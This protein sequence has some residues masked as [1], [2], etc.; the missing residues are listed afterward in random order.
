[1]TLRIGVLCE[2]DS[3]R[4]EV[5]IATLQGVWCPWCSPACWCQ[6]PDLRLCLHGP[7]TSASHQCC[8]LT[9]T[10]R[11]V[12]VVDTT[13]DCPVRPPLHWH[14]DLVTMTATLTPAGRRP[15]AAP[16]EAGAAPPQSAGGAGV[17]RRNVPVLL[18]AGEE[19]FWWGS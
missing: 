3:P 5:F 6:L 18:V 13:A 9:S 10:P 4:D 14:W 2:S 7:D 1:M 17:V 11:R 16:G 15:P 8:L 12:D 19:M